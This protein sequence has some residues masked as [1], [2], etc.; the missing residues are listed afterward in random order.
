MNELYKSLSPAVRDDL[1]RLEKRAI[2]PAGTKLISEAVA[3]ER[4]IVIERG[5]VEISVP[6]GERAMSLNVAGEGKVLG[7]RSII[8]GAVPEIEATTLEEC[9]ISFIS[10][11]DF[12]KV[13]EQN[14]EMYFAIAKVLS[15]DLNTAERFLREA[16]RIANKPRASNGLSC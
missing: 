8:A 10:R 14:P 7:L 9:A 2:V 16:P 3:P 12:L 6:A 1:S 5:S 11:Q 13:L 15:A 4:V